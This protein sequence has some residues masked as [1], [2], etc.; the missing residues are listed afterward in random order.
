VGGGL[1]RMLA[2]LVERRDPFEPEEREEADGHGDRDERRSVSGREHLGQDVEEHHTENGSRAE[3][4]Q[5]VQSI[6]KT[7]GRKT[8]KSRR[9]ECDA[10]Q[11]QRH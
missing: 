2:R 4:E 11:Q 5:E 8:P 1:M 7:D 3:A 9:Y 10:G 6:P